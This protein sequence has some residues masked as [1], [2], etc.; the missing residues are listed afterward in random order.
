MNASIY[1]ITGFFGAGKTQ[2]CA[3]LVE[4]ARSCGWEVSGTLCPGRYTG[5]R[6]TGIYVMDQRTLEMRL[7]ARKS[8]KPGK[9]AIQ[10]GDWVFSEQAMAWGDEVLKMAVPT[11]LLV[12][13]ELGPFELEFGQGWQSGITALNSRAFRAAL[14]VVRPDLIPRALAIWP[15]A[16]T[17]TLSTPGD[18][19]SQAAQL[20][21]EWLLA[22]DPRIRA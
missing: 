1:I 12:V 18:G 6:K 20:S 2:F 7:L 15:D 4:Q 14:L 9:S 19:P 13:D 5:K 16:R 22:A 17:V 8:K 11:D 21:A 10:L 3:G